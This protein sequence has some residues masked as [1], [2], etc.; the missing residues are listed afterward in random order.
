MSKID[1]DNIAIELEIY[2]DL[3]S[4]F[5]WDLKKHFIGQYD[6]DFD[7]NV[8]QKRLLKELYSIYHHISDLHTDL[9]FRN[10]VGLLEIDGMEL[11]Y[12]RINDDD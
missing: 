4:S 5:A 9:I 12:S 11:P 7:T 8:E 6:S 1:I 2:M 3:V 10:V